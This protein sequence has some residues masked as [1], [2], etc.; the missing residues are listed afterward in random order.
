VTPAGQVVWQHTVSSEVARAY[1]Y[2]ADYPGL[3]VLR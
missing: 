2:E 3:A 1:R